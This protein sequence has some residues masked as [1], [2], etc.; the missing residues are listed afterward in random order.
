MD[1]DSYCIIMRSKATQKFVIVRMPNVMK[2]IRDNYDVW[3]DIVP[4][5]HAD[6]LAEMKNKRVNDKADELKSKL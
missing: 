6:K 5:S 2:S 3:I 1:G 4:Q